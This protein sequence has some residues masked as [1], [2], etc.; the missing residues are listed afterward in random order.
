MVT[1]FEG[2]QK[3]FILIKSRNLATVLLKSHGEPMNAY[4]MRHSNISNLRGAHLRKRFGTVSA[5]QGTNEY[6]SGK[7]PVLSE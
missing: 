1:S 5:I 7:S 3:A 2:Q 4:A 6:D